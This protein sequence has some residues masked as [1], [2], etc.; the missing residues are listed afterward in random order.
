MT[1]AKPSQPASSPPADQID[2][3]ADDDQEDTDQGV[4]YSYHDN[5][6]GAGTF[7]V[8]TVPNIAQS[9]DPV[10][11]LSIIDVSSLS[12]SQIEANSFQNPSTLVP[13]P[14]DE[15]MSRSWKYSDASSSATWTQQSSSLT[16]TTYEIEEGEETVIEESYQ[17]PSQPMLES[18]PINPFKA[19]KFNKEFYGR[20]K[21]RILLK[22]QIC[23]I[24]NKRLLKKSDLERH[25]R[26]HTGTDD[27]DA[28]TFQQVPSTSS[29]QGQQEN[30]VFYQTV[31]PVTHAQ[32]FQQSRDKADQSFTTLRRLDLCTPPNVTLI[33]YS[34]A[35]S[36]S[37]NVP[38]DRKSTFPP[39]MHSP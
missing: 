31:S 8:T 1:E 34:E 29:D 22:K 38:T 14:A 18:I 30:F 13:R 36:D 20:S 6:D 27:K 32:S 35:V 11:N 12:T 25:I 39:E 7:I 10:C 2:L 5:S 9:E 33:P 37:G 26:T 24:C 28:R 15:A 17:D 23:H 3:T 4:V 21:T 19:V 16:Q